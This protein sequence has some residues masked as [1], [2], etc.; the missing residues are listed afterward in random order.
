MQ[1]PKTSFDIVLDIAIWTSRLYVGLDTWNVKERMTWQNETLTFELVGKMRGWPRKKWMELVKNDF[2]SFL[3]LNMVNAHHR[4]LWKSIIH[5]RRTWV[6]FTDH[7]L[8]GHASKICCYLCVP[9]NEDDARYVLRHTSCYHKMVSINEM[10]IQ[11][12]LFG[13]NELSVVDICQDVL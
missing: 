6:N 9:L 3:G 10:R 2:R 1:M 12:T 4:G 7:D 5:G 13:R 11:W 8:D